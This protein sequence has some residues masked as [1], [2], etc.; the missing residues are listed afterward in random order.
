MTGHYMQ[1]LFRPEVI[2]HATRRLDGAVLLPA[3]LAAWGAVAFVVAVLALGAWFAATA[4]YTRKESAPGW[5][6]PQGGVA[7]AVAGR[8]GTVTALLVSEGDIVE[9]GTPLA[10]IATDGDYVV[11]APIRGRVEALAAR[12]GQSV[13]RSSTVAVLAANDELMAELL[14]SP[15]AAGFVAVGQELRLKYDVLPF[16][17]HGV[18]QGV[19]THVSRTVLAPGE[20]ANAGIPVTEPVFHVRVRLPAQRVE[21]GG[22]S[23]PLRAGMLLTADILGHRRTLFESLFDPEA[24][25][26]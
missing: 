15:R 12:V 14:V 26:P 4:T 19:V 2:A 25:T 21:A 7:R 20:T 6:S 1:P 17:R 5:L 10:V 13:S 8:R 3:P 23:V 16:G 24:V 11:T 18:Q 22:A 9:A